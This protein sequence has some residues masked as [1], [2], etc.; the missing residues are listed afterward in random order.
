MKIRLISSIN[1]TVVTQKFV[2][3]TLSV[4][5]GASVLFWGLHS[6]HALIGTNY[7]LQLG[8]PSNA[9]AD[10]TNHNHYLILRTV[11]AL[12][13]SDNFGEPIWASWDLTAGDVGSS[14]RSGSFFTDTTLPPGF[15]E[16]TTADYNGVG[17]INFNRGH[18]CPS[19]DRTDN[20]NDNDLV[21][22]MSNIM[23]QA[24]TNNQGV[25]GNLEDYCRTL[26]QSGNELLIICGG[27]GF[28]TNRI[29]SGKAVIPDNT[30]K[31]AVVVPPGTNSAVNRIDANTRVIAVEIPNNNSVSSTWQDYVTSAHQ[32][33]VDTGLTFF[34]AL[35]PA[36]ASA[37]RF[38]VDGQT[39]GATG[40]S[41]F[42]PTSGS[43]GDSVVITGTNFSSAT[44]VAFNGVSATYS[45]DSSNQITAQ[46]PAN[47]TSGHI[48]VTTTSGTATSSGNFTVLS[49]P[50]VDLSVIAMHSGN[51]TQGDVADTYTIIVTNIGTLASSGSVSVTDSLPVGL[52]A[53]AISGTGWTTNLVTLTCT[54]SDSLSVGA[55]FPPITVTVSVATNAPATVTNVVSV[56]GGGDTNLANN[57]SGDVTVIN[58][59]AVVPFTGV[60]AGWDVHALV[61]FGPTPFAATNVATNLTVNGLARLSG[62]GTSGT[63]A[64]NA[65]GG[66]GFVDA[67]SATAIANNRY[68]T[69]SVM[70]NNGFKVSFSTLN[71]FNYRRSGAGPTN[72]LLQCQIG[73]GVFSNIA[74]VSYTSSSSSGATL[75]PIDLSGIAAL[76]NVPAGSNVTFRIVNWG[77]T[78]SG[79]TWYVF[80]V[81]NSTALD[82][83]VQGTVTPVLTPIESWR[84]QYF[85]TTANNGAAADTAIATS[86]G[87]PNL[88]KYAFGLNPLTPS[89]NPTAGDISTGFLRLTVPKNPNATDISFHVELSTSLPGSSWNT[90]GTVIDQNTATL[91]QVHDSQP[92]NAS[93]S[94]FLRLRVSRP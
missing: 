22:Y 68:V 59:S 50:T 47:A 30:W 94:G 87:M 8:N 21:F 89:V 57:S 66:T 45:V 54:R 33:E 85:G 74:T 78:S 92:V 5:A 67:D 20:T 43:V 35:P 26:A 40:I 31:I 32:I 88:L 69:F 36:V 39:N 91:L 48:S 13:Y 62:V 17:N 42:S 3:K 14:G 19:D 86:D 77:G 34:T 6:A 60:L 16:V 80:D 18:L 73:S 90:N 29:P 49:S 37:L 93:A 24:A 58:S 70:V 55:S 25:W 44:A 72:G 53:T 56:S 61:N 46:V 65:W 71:P 63:A 15:Y 12:D 81:T 2:R 52:T 4:L 51:F 28:G 11:E 84:L 75:G 23:P 9:T 10:P 7:Q 83:A 64:S 27:S 1:G 76:Q 38:K 41:N 79:G 82:F